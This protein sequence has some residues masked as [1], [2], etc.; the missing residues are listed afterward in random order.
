MRVIMD[1]Q[2]IAEDAPDFTQGVEMARQRAAAAGRL[3]IE[4]L[5]DGVA[6]DDLLDRAN[7]HPTGESP[8][9]SDSIAELGITTADKGLFLRETLMNARDALEA[10]RADQQRAGERI[11]AGQVAEALSALREIVAGWQAVRSVVDQAAALAGVPLDALATGDVDGGPTTGDRVIAALA[12]DLSRIRDSVA[13][14]DW[15]LLSETLAFD[16]DA[17]AAEW[18]GLIDALVA[19]TPGASPV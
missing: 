2:T 14:E 5:A 12:T 8:T 17:R 11:D 3:V 10:T 15:S 9:E 7:A 6:A 18:S 1:G 4:V 13:R 19:R 16:L